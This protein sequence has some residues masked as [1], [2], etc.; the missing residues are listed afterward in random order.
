MRQIYKS[1]AVQLTGEDN[2]LGLQL[3]EG[4]P[5]VRYYSTCCGTPLMTDYTMM[6]F[7]LIYQHTIASDDEN[8]NF[9]QIPATVVLNHQSAP[10]DSPATPEGIPVRDG[11]SLGFV[12]HALARAL[13][14]MV[15]GKKSSPI[16]AQL[17]KIPVIIGTESMKDS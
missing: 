17:E 10:S 5:C 7:Y 8:A 1:D 14:G 11:V 16:A 2:L 13:V 15:S 9:K 12:S 4:S 3:K 6:P